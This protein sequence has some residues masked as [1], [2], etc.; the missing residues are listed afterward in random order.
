M[1]R[2]GVGQASHPS[3]ERAAEEAAAQAMG[4]AGISAADLVLVFFTVDHLPSWRKLVAALQRVSRTDQIVGSSGVGVLTI[5]GEIEGKAGLAVMVVASDDTRARAFLHQPLS[6]RDAEIGAEVGRSASAGEESLLVA[7]PDAYNSQPRAL[8]RGLED[9]SGFVPL[10]GAGSSENGSQGKTFQLYGQTIATNA[11]AGF[12]LSGRFTSRIGI[13]QGCQP[14]SAPMTITKTEGNLILEIDNRPAFEV[15]SRIVKGPLLENLGRALAYIF[16][17][18]P[19]DTGKNSVGP[20][21]Y[22][23][24][25]IVGLDPRAGVLAVAE[26][27]F[28]GE[29]IVF[30]L[31]DAEKAREDLGQMLQRQAESL[32][33]K[34]PAL[35]F[36]FNCCARGSSLYGMDGIDVAYIRQSLGE[37]P[38]I[39]LFGS[40]ELGPLGKK[41]HLLA[42]TGVLA[43]IADP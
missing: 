8:F 27:I 12:S 19:V 10:V 1:I 42:Y 21:E 36:Y 20:G 26:E 9:S 32:G 40:F 31:R 35:G 43:L 6:G 38:L 25:N 7:F 2:A 41:N 24:R 11:L 37:F 5:D 4:R 13:T 18:L 14:V 15:F 22:L 34:R 3:T 17:G 30:T 28:E 29:R 23:V 16:V 33:G 39:G